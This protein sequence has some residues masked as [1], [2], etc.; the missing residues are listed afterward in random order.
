MNST[1]VCN[2]Q[3]YCNQQAIN[4]LSHFALGITEILFTSF[5]I[6]VNYFVYRKIQRNNKPEFLSRERL[7]RNT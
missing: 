2:C 4:S 3:D 5:N 1:N 6:I 7:Y